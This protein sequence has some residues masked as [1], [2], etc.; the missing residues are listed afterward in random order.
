MKDFAHGA[1]CALVV[2][3]ASACMTTFGVECTLAPDGHYIC[4]QGS[5]VDVNNV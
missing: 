2:L 5:T 4:Q 1:I 3:L